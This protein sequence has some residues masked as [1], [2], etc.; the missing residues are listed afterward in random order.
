MWG[1]VVFCHRCALEEAAEEHCSKVQEPHLEWWAPES[2]GT[3]RRGSARIDMR[4]GET[5][6][7]AVARCSKVGRLVEVRSNMGRWGL[8]QLG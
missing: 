8:L 3:R 1:E 6:G 7:E 5:P 2:V 4:F